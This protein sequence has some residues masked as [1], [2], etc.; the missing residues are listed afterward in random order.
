MKCTIILGNGNELKIDGDDIIAL[1]NAG[2]LEVTSYH[3]DGMPATA[4]VTEAGY[5]YVKELEKEKP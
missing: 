3:N 2:L 5:E 1:I 4:K